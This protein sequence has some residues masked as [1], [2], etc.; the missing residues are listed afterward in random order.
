MNT[1]AIHTTGLGKRYGALW[2]LQDCSVSVP[3]GHITALVGPNGA[4]KTTLLK[5][6][7]GLSAPST[8]EAAVLGRAPRQNEDFLA[9]IGQFPLDTRDAKLAM[10][11]VRHRCHD[12]PD[13]TWIV[14]LISEKDATAYSG[15]FV[16]DRA[17]PLTEGLSLRGAI[18]GA[19][20]SSA[21]DGGP[22]V[23]AGNVP[24]LADVTLALVA[25]FSAWP[26][27]KSASMNLL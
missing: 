1:P 9:S 10:K 2:A 4:G 21:L 12:A 19:G 17:H 3:R 13:N 27:R 15:P 20:K 18:W 23:M 8:G 24:L 25:G 7:A 14:Q 26:P 11:W 22:V 6:L 16:L 5:I